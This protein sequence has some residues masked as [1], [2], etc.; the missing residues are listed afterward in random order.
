MTCPRLGVWQSGN[1]NPGPG[2]VGLLRCLQLRTLLLLPADDRGSRTAAQEESESTT[3]PQA[4][5]A[6]RTR[7]RQLES[8]FLG[9]HCSEQECVCL[10]VLCV[11]R[12]AVEG[13]EKFLCPSKHLR[14]FLSTRASSENCAAG[15]GAFSA[16]VSPTNFKSCCKV[17][18][19][20]VN[21]AHAEAALNS[22]GRIDLISR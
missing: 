11:V 20:L 16:Q 6:P 21:G 2:G 5:W 18:V 19:L 10:H 12:A 14:L 8:S 17:S 13:L 22:M 3:A 15:P 4:S 7:P 1:L 9:R